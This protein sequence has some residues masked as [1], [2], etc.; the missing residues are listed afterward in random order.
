MARELD[1]KPERGAHELENAIQF[2]DS[3]GPSLTRAFETAASGSH[4]EVSQVEKNL[5]FDAT[6]P[7]AKVASS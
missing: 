5:P 2:L 4:S 3:M 7:T 1:W 6:F